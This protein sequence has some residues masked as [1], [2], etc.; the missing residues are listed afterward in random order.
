MRE[1]NLFSVSYSKLVDLD[2][3]YKCFDTLFIVGQNSQQLKF[4]FTIA[5]GWSVA[6]RRC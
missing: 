4:Q 3:G 5:N 2:F 1:A 6:A